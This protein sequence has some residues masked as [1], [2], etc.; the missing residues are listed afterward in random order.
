[1]AG[2]NPRPTSRQRFSASCE[3][4]PFHKTILTR[5][6]IKLTALPGFGFV[7]VF[8]V[9][10]A[11]VFWD[12]HVDFVLRGPDPVVFFVPAADLVLRGG[13]DAYGP[14]HAAEVGAPLAAGLRPG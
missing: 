10:V 6:S 12:V 9:Q 5:F 11:P 3:A 8:E 4:V 7:L 13:A 2:I 1:M 14:F